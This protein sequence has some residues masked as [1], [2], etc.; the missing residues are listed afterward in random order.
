[1][2]GN[3]CLTWGRQSCSTLTLPPRLSGNSGRCVG[4]LY[5]KHRCRARRGNTLFAVPHWR[6][7]EEGTLPPR[8]NRKRAI[9]THNTAISPH[10]FGRPIPG[11]H[12][13]SRRPPPPAIDSLKVS[14]PSEFD[15]ADPGP[16]LGLRIEG[17]V[18]AQASSQL[19]GRETLTTTKPPFPRLFF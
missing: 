12:V 11:T 15:A 16:D 19:G 2:R 3:G 18:Q 1:M 17:A 6:G 5:S 14:L 10:G 9:W 7:K 8:P 13:S 4:L